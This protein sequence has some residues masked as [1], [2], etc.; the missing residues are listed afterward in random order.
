MFLNIHLI[1]K[2]SNFQIFSVILIW[3]VGTYN[4]IS[5]FVDN[6]TGILIKIGKCH[7]RFFFFN[8]HLSFVKLLMGISY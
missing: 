7:F 2:F 3:P 8:P 5:G 6:E 4:Q 1:I